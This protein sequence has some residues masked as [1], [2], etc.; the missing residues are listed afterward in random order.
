MADNKK[1]KLR[2]ARNEDRYRAMLGLRSS[3]AATPQTL[4]ARKG[5][6]TAQKQKAIRDWN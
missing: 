4:K 2:P 1:S 6:R 5:T 3:S